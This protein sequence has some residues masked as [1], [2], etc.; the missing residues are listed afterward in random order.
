MGKINV[1]IKNDKQIYYNQ[2]KGEI[3]E[4]NICEDYSSVTLVVGRENYRN[5]NL[6]C[7]TQFFKE[8][9]SKYSLGDKIVC[10]FYIAS[11]KKNDRWF[12]TATLLSIIMDA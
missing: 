1:M 4:I 3:K 2:I 5:V 11:N 6:S 9:I 10:H 8:M 7:K 12:T